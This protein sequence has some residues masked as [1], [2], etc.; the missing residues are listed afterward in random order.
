MN[1]EKAILTCDEMQDFQGMHKVIKR[2]DPDSEDSYYVD[3][4]HNV[5]MGMHTSLSIPRGWGER[6]FDIKYFEK[7]KHTYNRKDGYYKR[8]DSRKRFQR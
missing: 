5:I 6:L 1:L 4:D 7:D 2:G 3:Y 8:L